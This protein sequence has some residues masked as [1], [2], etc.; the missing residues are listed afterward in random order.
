MTQSKLGVATTCYLTAWRPKDAYE[1]LEHCHG[2]GAAGVQVAL[3]GDMKK[4]QA[5]AEEYGMYIEAMLPL[6]KD[7][8]DTSAFERA[9]KNANEAGVACGRSNS[10]GRLY[11]EFSSEAPYREW[12]KRADAAL[13]AAVPLLEKYKVALGVE[14]HKDRQTD[15]L[16]GL[17]K[18]YSSEYLGSCVDCGNSISLL[19]SPMET[20]KKLAPYAITTHFKDMAVASYPDGFLLSEVLLGQGDLDLP[21]IVTVLKKEKPKIHFLLEMITRDPL[22]IPCLTDRYWAMFPNRPA[23]DL[24]RTLRYV[25]EKGRAEKSLPHMSQLSHDQ[26]VRS[27]DE[28]VKL[29]LN[30]A[31]EKLIF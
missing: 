29:C 6:P 12:R 27:E 18:Q 10:G 3:N 28:N 2:L 31:R 9:L 20:I 25:Q 21:Q 30:Y 19:E 15:E 17:L 16:V 4:L 14:N 8:N 5:R 26:Q 1:F 7:A 24:A 13:G 23:I 11:E 22:K